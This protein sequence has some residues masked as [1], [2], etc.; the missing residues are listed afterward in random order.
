MRKYAVAALAAVT[1]LG[2]VLAA[3]STDDSDDGSAS[4][5][6]ASAASTAADPSDAV[7]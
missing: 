1:S 5:N 2:L 3:C 4:G 7:N 6:T